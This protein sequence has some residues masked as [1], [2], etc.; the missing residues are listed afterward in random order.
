MKC[1]KCWYCVHI[2]A[3]IYADF[4]VK[5]CKY[6]KKY[7]LPFVWIKEKDGTLNQRQLDFRGMSDCKIWHEVGCNIHPNTVKKAKNDFIRTLEADKE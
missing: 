4:P 2:G 6:S 3:G 1:D 5:Y 7:K